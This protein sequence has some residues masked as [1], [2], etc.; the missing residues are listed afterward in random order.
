MSKDFSAKFFIKPEV[1]PQAASKA[2]AKLDQVVA[3]A[4]AA[5]KAGNEKALRDLNIEAHRILKKGGN[6]TLTVEVDTEFSSTTAGLQEVKRMSASALDPYIKDYQKALDIQEAAFNIKQEIGLQKQNLSELKKK[7]EILGR[8]SKAYKKNAEAQKLNVQQTEKLQ[9][10]LSKVRTLASLKGQLRDESQKLSMMNQYNVGLNKQGELVTTLNQKWVAQRKVVMGLQGQVSA[11]G[12]AAQG[13]GA[14]VAAAGQKMQM[15][16]GWIAAVVAGMTAIAGSIG[17]ITGRAKDVQA[18]RL[19]F[20]GLGQSVEAQNAILGSARNI[21][22]SYGVSL[23][24]VEGA[25]RRLGPAILE[26]GGSLKDTEG[27]IKSIAARPRCWAEHEQAGRYIEA[28]AQVMGKGKPRSEELNQQFSE[29]DGGL[30]GQLKN[31]LAANKGTPTS[32]MLQEWRNYRRRLPGG[33]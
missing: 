10:A 15:A 24:K 20:D 13:F 2:E 6:P 21:A 8:G 4:A 27:A 33:I 14:K 7:Q 22:L 26:S 30:R 9:A 12:A 28:F 17:A 31:W 3:Q 25:F 32:R 11:A 16:F 29:L 23:R 1:D 5:A 18:I 19:T